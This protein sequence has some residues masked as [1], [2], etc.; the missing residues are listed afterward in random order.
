MTA[1]REST[2]EMQKKVLADSFDALEPSAVEPTG[3]VQ[4][5]SARVWCLD[6]DAL[7]DEHLE[8]PSRTVDAVPFGHLASSCSSET[9]C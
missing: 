8:T 3:E 7:A 1:E 5:A 9:R 2:F 4:R 6:L